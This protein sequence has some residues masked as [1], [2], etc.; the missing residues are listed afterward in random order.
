MIL[1]G[2]LLVLFA[3]AI[4]L[5]V[6]FPCRD[7]LVQEFPL[8]AVVREAL[9]GGHVPYWD[10]TAS[11]GQP[12]AA[13]PEY[14][15][16]Y[17]PSWL[18]L[19]PGYPYGLSLLIVFHLVLGWIGFFRLGRELGLDTETAFVGA[20]AFGLSGLYLS[21]TNLPPAFFGSS[22]IPWILMFGVRGFRRRRASDTALAALALGMQFL[23]GEPT[24]A[25]QTVILL[26][27]LAIFFGW[28]SPER[29]RSLR[30]NA[31][32]LTAMIVG[33]L[34]VAAVQLIPAADFFRD[35][36]RARGFNPGLAGAW[37]LPPIRLPELAIDRWFGPMSG[38]SGIWYWGRHFYRGLTFPYFY[39]I[40]L[41]VL[42]VSLGLASL[43]STSRWRTAAW[44]LLLMFLIVA[45][46][47]WTPLFSLLGRTPL[48]RLTRFPEKF[49]IGAVLI[50]VLCAAAAFQRILEGDERIRRTA[51]AVAGGLTLLSGALVGWSWSAGYADAFGKL[52]GIR[53]PGL[54][55]AVTMSRGILGVST[56]WGLAATGTWILAR[57]VRPR[58]T[59]MIVCAILLGELGV[60]SIRE[61]PRMPRTF[62]S[63]PEAL[64]PVEKSGRIFA[65]AELRENSAVYREYGDRLR[66]QQD[67]FYFSRNLLAGR[68]PNAWGRDLVMEKDVG[69][70]SLQPTADFV[71]AFRE[72]E[73]RRGPESIEQ[74]LGMSGARYT[75]LYRPFE[76]EWTR[77]RGRFE[78][79]QPVQ[80][81]ATP[82]PKSYFATSL[83]RIG[84]VDDFVK[85]LVSHPPRDR[86][87][88]V[89]FQPF[90][91]AAGRVL[92]SRWSTNRITF[93]VKAEGK[94]FLVVCET[95]H[96]YWRA[97][98]DG[99]TVPL[100]V[101]N[102]GFQGVVVG[103]GHHRIRMTYRNPLIAWSG[104]ISLISL[105]L[106]GVVLYRGRSREE[107]TF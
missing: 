15:L 76:S 51:A 35:T 47:V 55:A 80:I 33:A 11:A 68:L 96:R 27:A 49:L 95:P 40:H 90:V 61:C 69:M 78:T 99:V 92:S 43:R 32:L 91:P 72:V 58:T 84:G 105:M 85:Q 37:S 7:L 5:G 100:R 53:P 17:P 46:G 42:V 44:A 81:V 59:M 67:A 107:P 89:Q 45:F 104:V 66:T 10:P 64:K 106:I 50:F 62:L 31:T 52:W 54:A 86:T 12:L 26:A 16:F 13:N 65:L 97:T 9:L 29:M 2:I 57:R 41:G 103:P 93:D 24:F 22:W 25:L 83:V 30:I 4:F 23:L 34:G 82:H 38:T 60:L 71:R 3:D 74:F 79:M 48:G 94:A 36:V 28:T 14:E 56:A 98:I 21:S 73:A 77:T 87:A 6:V 39:S 63:E 102:I 8:H 88:F 20:L 1:L 70:T 18:A 75:T 19:L 101:T